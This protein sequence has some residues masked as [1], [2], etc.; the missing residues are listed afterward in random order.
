[1]Y[2]WLEQSLYVLKYCLYS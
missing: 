1:M 2:C